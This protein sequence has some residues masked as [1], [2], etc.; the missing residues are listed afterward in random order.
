MD[1]PVVNGCAYP[2]ME[3]QQTAYRFKILNACNDRTLNLQL[4]NAVSNAISYTLTDKGTV[5]E[6]HLN[7]GEV[8][9]IPACSGGLQ[10]PPVNG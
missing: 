2:Y 6:L 1:T 9:M 10:N 7:S 3:V 8:P 5:G 4:H